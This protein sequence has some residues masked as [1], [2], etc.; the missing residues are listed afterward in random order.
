MVI[1]AQ[2]FAELEA[3]PLN[4]GWSAA[5]HDQLRRYIAESFIF[6]E[7]TKDVC[8]KWAELTAE[9]K[10]NGRVIAVGDAWIAATALAYSIPLVTH[11]YQDFNNVS[12]LELISEREK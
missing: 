9:A 5:R 11:N 6:I 10:T 3:W 4:N 1:A 12:G 7:T 8:L 2:T